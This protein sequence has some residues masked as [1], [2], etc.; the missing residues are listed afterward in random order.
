MLDSRAWLT[1][2]TPFDSIFKEIGDGRRVSLCKLAIDHLDKTGQPLRL[3]VDFAIWSFQA[4]A[5]RGGANPAIRTLFYRLIRLLSLSIVPIFVFDGPNKPLFK[6]NKRSRGPGD[7]VSVAMAKDLF[8]RFGFHIH[9]APGEAEAECALLQQ[10]GIVDAVLSEDVDTIM[11]GCTKTLRNWSAQAIRSASAPTHVSV[12]DVVDLK[13]GET[14]LDREGMVLVALMSGGDYI[15]EGVPGCGIKLACEA[16]KAGFGHSLC[17][18]KR[19]DPNAVSEW[20]DILRRE[21]QTNE[22][23]FFR[24]KHKAVKIPDEFP[25]MDVLRYYTHPVVSQPAT[26]ERLRREFPSQKEM[27]LVG[28]RAFTARTFDW[29]YKSG[30][31]RLIKILAPSVLN[32]LML[33]LSQSGIGSDDPGVREA[34]EA[35]IVKAIKSRRTHFNTDATPELRISYI[36]KDVVPLDLDAEEDEPVASYG[37]SGLALN[38]DEEEEEIQAEDGEGN[39]SKMFDPSQ[40]NLA[41]VPEIVA[42]LG[43]PLTVEDWEESQ[44]SKQLAKEKKAPKKRPT[45]KKVP[46]VPF[47]ALDRWVTTT[48]PASSAPPKEAETTPILLSSSPQ[49]APPISLSPRRPRPQ[50]KTT[51]ATQDTASPVDEAFRERPLKSQR[52]NPSKAKPPAPRR[53]LDLDPWS[54]ASSQATPKTSRTKDY[55]NLAGSQPQDAILIL[56][57]PECS[58]LAES[59]TAGN[60][61]YGLHMDLSGNSPDKSSPRVQ[62]PFKD[63]DSG[64]PSSATGLDYTTSPGRL[65][66]RA[67]QPRRIRG[68]YG[69]SRTNATSR[70]TTGTTNRSTRARNA[71]AKAAAQQ[72]SIKNFGRN[73]ETTAKTR[74]VPMDKPDFV[75]FD[76]GDEDE[77]EGVQGVRASGNRKD[78]RPPPPLKGKIPARSDNRNSSSWLVAA[79]INADRPESNAGSARARLPAKINDNHDDNTSANDS[80]LTSPAISSV[81]EMTRLYRT[82]TAGFFEEV[83]VSRAQAEQIMSQHELEN[84]GGVDWSRRMWTESEVTFLDLTGEDSCLNIA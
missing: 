52:N 6:R 53:S 14:G 36:P 29:T 12:Y 3:A 2:T 65:S 71:K 1:V 55:N 64:Q 50:L 46:V 37:R 61:G 38:S 30:A 23:K 32:Q 34:I 81:S 78:F 25:D 19:S 74:D 40:P 70:S 35:R 18:L 20:R 62:D 51:A 39:T 27:D 31:I 9:D 16:A 80:P 28:L 45:K 82:S 33:K 5:A 77:D 11:F 21:L 76:R 24:R 47:G 42:K 26:L 17:N 56:S 83:L 13:Q 22:S 7:T 15:P 54:I 10:Q 84:P 79:G 69:V 4:Q 75:A 58:R 48:K 68:I 73:T 67:S 57:S 8:A 66:P 49:L 63:C 41:W 72:S 43:V 44:S 59:T 60:A